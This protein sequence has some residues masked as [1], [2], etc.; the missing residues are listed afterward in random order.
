M[1]L[2]DDNRCFTCGMD[3]LE[4]LRLEWKVMG[5]TIWILTSIPAWLKSLILLNVQSKKNDGDFLR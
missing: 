3:N 2:I 4:G 5:H 1:E